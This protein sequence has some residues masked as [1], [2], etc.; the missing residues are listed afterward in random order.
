MTQPLGF[1][2]TSSPTHVCHL[3]RAIYGLRQAPRAWFDQ[4]STFLLKHGFSRSMVDTSM[5]TKH[6]TYGTLIL[7][8]YV[9]DI[10]L[11]GD[12]GYALSTF[13]KC[14]S[15]EF[16]MT[17]LGELHY[18]LGVEATRTMAGLRLTQTKYSLDL[19]LKTI[20]T[21]C[22]PCRTSVASGSKLSAADGSTLVDPHEC[23]QVVGAL[24]YLTLTHPDL[25]YSVNQVCQFMHAP[26]TAHYD[27][28]KR[29][30][31]YLKHTL[32]AG[33]DIKPGPISI[34]T[35]FT[36]ADWA[37]CPDTRRSTTG[38]CIF[39][40]SNLLSWGSKKQP[41]V[42]HSSSESEYKALVVTISEVLW[43][44]YLLDDLHVP[45]SLPL[46]INCDNI[47]T[48]YMAA[49]PVRHARTKHI[50][51]D[52]HFVRELVLTKKIKV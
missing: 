6:S 34:V 22:K 21:S 29:I 42:S 17:D 7:L 48:T 46:I 52:Y 28:I 16:A 32:G 3:H 10:I 35:T 36:D 38:F 47:S 24:Q 37:G 13:I 2:S 20:M 1:V 25:S 23:R 31:R 26:T 14:L 40:G 4:F 43:L 33:I 30:L 15:T 49:N 18:F 11:T 41:T 19:L 12:N 44:S 45:I 51:V 5:F 27:A 9:D 8:L 50:E 39:L